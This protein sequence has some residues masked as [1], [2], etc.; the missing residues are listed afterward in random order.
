MKMRCMNKMSLE[1]AVLYYC[2]ICG[3]VIGDCPICDKSYSAALL[4]FID[5]GK[6]GMLALCK[7]CLNKLNLGFKLR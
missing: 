7:R 6:E 3:K 5:E 4:I 1:K 2:C